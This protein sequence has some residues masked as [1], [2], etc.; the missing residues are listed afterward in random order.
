MYSNAKN[1][2]FVIL[3][4]RM[5]PEGVIK[6]DFWIF[7]F[8]RKTPGAFDLDLKILSFDDLFQNS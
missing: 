6:P 4:V 7:V 5:N 1:E 8:S 3:R 2:V